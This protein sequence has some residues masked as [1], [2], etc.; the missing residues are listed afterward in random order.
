MKEQ[1]KEFLE[2]ITNNLL[3]QMN[4]KFSLKEEENNI[5]HEYATIH[6]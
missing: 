2:M 1:K 6:Q 3:N 5:K 4:L